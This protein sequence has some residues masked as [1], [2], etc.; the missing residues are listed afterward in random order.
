MGEWEAIYKLRPGRI[1][2]TGSAR[3]LTVTPTV[4]IWNLMW[5]V[6]IVEGEGC[7]YGA[8]NGGSFLICVTQK[9]TWILHK[10]V[11]LYGGGITKQRTNDPK[12][13]YSRWQLTG[14]RARGLAIAIE[15]YL[16]PRRRAQL[17]KVRSAK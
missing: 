3:Q 11:G 5:T 10:L 12:K 1:G 7:F 17:D 6:G 16:S 8:R 4:R 14:G 13:M 15:P 9:D 2:R